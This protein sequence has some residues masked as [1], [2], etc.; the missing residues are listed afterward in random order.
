MTESSK[1]VAL[2]M[3]R[4]KFAFEMPSH[5]PLELEIRQMAVG[6]EV[7]VGVVPDAAGGVD[8]RA[9]RVEAA[10]QVAA[11]QLVVAAHRHLDRGPAVPEHIERRADTRVEIRPLGHALELVD[12]ARQARTALRAGP[13]TDSHW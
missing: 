12:V 1:S 3:N 13:P 7:A 4:P 2:G 6:D 8:R 10:R 9:E 5:S 11:A